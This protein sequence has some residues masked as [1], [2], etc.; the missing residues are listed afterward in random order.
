MNDYSVIFSVTGFIEIVVKA[1]SI[2]EAKQKAWDAF[3]EDDMK[4]IG[5]DD[6]DADLEDIEEV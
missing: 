5:L 6:I 3:P 4:K 1:S 2:E